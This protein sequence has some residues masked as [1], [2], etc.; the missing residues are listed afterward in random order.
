MCCAVLCALS[1]LTPLRQ[2]PHTHFHV[3]R[4]A[5]DYVWQKRTT[6]TTTKSNNLY[7]IAANLLGNHTHT[8]RTAAA[9]AKAVATQQNSIK[10]QKDDK[11]IHNLTFECFCQ[12]FIFP[13]IF[14]EHK[15]HTHEHG[16]RH[17]HNKNQ[18]ERHLHEVYGKTPFQLIR[19]YVCHSKEST[20]N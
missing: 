15:T 7:E 5:C 13:S 14:F 17:R 19:F 12:F 6:T 3:Q 8:H 1:A 4:K 2:T 20:L 9:A 10:H 11:W 18:F 16:H